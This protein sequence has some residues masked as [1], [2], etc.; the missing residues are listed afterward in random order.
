MEEKYGK[1]ESEFV[2]VCTESRSGSVPFR[3]IK[4]DVDE[5]VL[6]MQAYRIYKFGEP[7]REMVIT[8]TSQVLRRKYLDMGHIISDKFRNPNGIDM[9]LSKIE[10]AIGDRTSTST[11]SKSSVF[12]KVVEMYI[13]SRRDFENKLNGLC[14]C[15]YSIEDELE[16]M[17]N[18]F[19]DT[20][21]DEYE[22]AQLIALFYSLQTIDSSQW[23]NTMQEFSEMLI[24]YHR[25][26]HP[27][28]S[29]S[30]L[31]AFSLFGLG[32][33]LHS[34]RML[35]ENEGIYD[36]NYSEQELR[37]FLLRKEDPE[38]FKSIIAPKT[39]AYT[40]LGKDITSMTMET[41]AWDEYEVARFIHFCNEL[42]EADSVSAVIRDF[43]EHLKMYAT[44]QGYSMD[45]SRN[46]GAINCRALQ[47]DYL[48]SDGKRGKKGSPKI[49][50]HIA[51][52]YIEKPEEYQELL[53]KAN[54]LLEYPNEAP[55]Q[56][57]EIE[58]IPNETSNLVVDASETKDDSALS[59][60]IP[61][62]KN[63]YA[64][65]EE[66]A[67]AENVEVESIVVVNQE[68]RTQEASGLDKY[69]MVME[70]F[71]GN[72]IRVTSRLDQNRFS[73]RYRDCHHEE[74]PK[75]NFE[76]TIRSICY[77]KEG[78]CFLRANREQAGLLNQIIEE[79]CDLF[80]QGY[81]CIYTA[82]VY[83][84]FKT[85][86]EETFEIY[87]EELFFPVL[88]QSVG[89][90]FSRNG[91]DHL[92]RNGTRLAPEEDVK[93][94]VREC[95]REISYEELEQ[96]LWFIPLTKI[97][98]AIQ[99][100]P[101]IINTANCTYMSIDTFPITRDDLKKVKEIIKTGIS[102]APKG[103]LSSEECRRLI[104]IECKPVKIDTE[105]FSL[106]GFHN[107]LGYLLRDDF[108]FSSKFVTE[109]DKK[110]DT[111]KLYRE[112]CEDRERF[113][114]DDLKEFSKE[115]NVLINHDIVRR[116]MIRIDEE[117]FW[118]SELIH[119]NA[120]RID[121][122]LEENFCRSE[123][124]PIQNT[125]PLLSLLPSVDGVRWTGYLLESYLFSFSKKFIL[126]H[127]GFAEKNFNGVMVKKTAGFEN[128]EQ[129]IV[130]VLSKRNGWKNKED[131]YSILTDDGYITRAKYNG[132]E[133]IMKMAKLKREKNKG[134][135]SV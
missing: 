126:M 129:L 111:A 72:G 16:K 62:D 102:T 37:L 15:G 74:M 110:I 86:I 24:D 52:I 59:I 26:I 30:E 21:W 71:F 7:T 40:E 25:K 9:Q 119:F 133:E 80:D 6:L 97:K 123:Y 65:E 122:S 108:A 73:Q 135:Y 79:L 77:E 53:Y 12:N 107:S 48:L 55:V 1:L 103:Q 51:Q 32:S 85:Q 125:E 88:M 50:Q 17:K 106:R 63:E 13:N 134:E 41:R 120:E 100:S 36:E 94:F 57:K 104:Y 11:W 45:L 33:R 132:I 23:D 42:K 56:E 75:T 46:A 27:E 124:L 29:A 67:V 22:T 38:K 43:I 8:A 60:Y 5:A 4:W 61:V 101:S 47:M 78:K 105:Q 81:T 112:F 10:I 70:Q 127:K 44:K 96:E 92:Y 130:D 68:K 93:K 87:G 64:M 128:Y 34:I 109:K 117:N 90:R 116:A 28:C 89:G 118:S 82:C 19:S 83:Q 54:E 58:S 2:G 69:R 35:E 14:E 76:E 39:L 91:H 84:H 49:D 18:D 98:Q 3:R 131:V 95:Q 66:C 115:I 114:L 20:V 113:C 31:N 99:K 121:E